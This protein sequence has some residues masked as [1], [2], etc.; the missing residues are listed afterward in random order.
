MGGSTRFFFYPSR[1]TTQIYGNPNDN[2][3]YTITIKIYSLAG[4]LVY[5]IKNASNGV[6][7]S[8]RDQTGY[9]LPP[10][11][12]LYQITADDVTQEKQ[13]KS[14]VQ[15]LVIHPPH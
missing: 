11:I 13:V 1:T 3:V 10:N 8:G 12:Y 7:W 14:K 5:V 9:P 15:K 6:P 4:K 2:P